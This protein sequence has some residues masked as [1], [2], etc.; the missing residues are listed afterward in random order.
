MS[1]SKI[2]VTL[3]GLMMVWGLNVSVL[4]I[5]V[6]HFQPA[7]I[8]ALRI[9]TAALIAF[10][11]LG[12]TRNIRMPKKNEWIYVFGG[13]LLS[14]TF[15][16]YFLSEGLTKTSATNAG[17]ILGMGP[18]L[19]V[20][21]SM[22]FFRKKPTLIRFLGFILGGLGVSFTVLAGSNG[23]HSIN[24]GDVDILFSIL[25][26]AFSFILINQAAKTMDPRLLTGYMLLFGS[27]FLFA[28]SLWKEPGGLAS[29]SAP[30][31]IWI[32]FFFSAVIATGLGHMIYN[33]A[34][35]QV[36][37]AETS[38]FLN[39]NTFFSLAGAALFLNEALVPAHFIGLILIV[40]GVLFGSGTLEAWVL[41]RKNKQIATE[42]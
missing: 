24:M 9:F 25:S 26:Q 23:V 21:L 13:A 7:T 8:T 19:T 3:I 1:H 39:L 29:L 27:F 20:I 30:P 22:L 35:G 2:Y 33:F 37:A 34:I 10:L 5:V 28:I 36:G 12:L 42:K 41:Q 16:H 17:L 18:L 4:K 32:A 11:Y 40:S 15:H 14:V 31:S 38:I 6:H